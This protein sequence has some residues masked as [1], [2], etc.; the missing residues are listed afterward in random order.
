MD[1]TLFDTVSG[2]PVMHLDTLK[3]SSIENGAEQVSA[4]GG[5]G[6]SKLISW[7]FGRTATLSITDALLTTKSF[8]LL[9][10]NA[11]VEGSATVHMRQDT[12]WDTSGATPVD[13]GDLFPL[14]ASGAGAQTTQKNSAARR[15]NLCRHPG[16]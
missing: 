7:D 9:S 6:N 10:G 12:V 1:V 14:I 11:T 4:T 2:K 15:G 5:K 8:Q 16:L 3:V 13:K